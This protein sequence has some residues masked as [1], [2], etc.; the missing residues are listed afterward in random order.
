V[1]WLLTLNSAPDGLYEI[2]FLGTQFRVNGTLYD[3]FPD[4]GV[5]YIDGSVDVTGVVDGRI[6]IAA[7][8]GMR[9]IGDLTYACAG[10]GANLPA[11]CDDV[12]GLNSQ[13]PI[14]I[15]YAPEDRI[16]HAAMAS[17]QNSVFVPE[18]ATSDWRVEG[19]T[20]PPILYIRGAVVGHYRGVFGG[21]DNATSDL[22]SFTQGELVSGYA[23]NFQ[24]DPRLVNKVPPPYFVNPTAA[25]WSRVDI[26]QVPGRAAFFTTGMV[27]PSTIPPAPTLPPLSTLPPLVTTTL[28]PIAPT[29]LPPLVTT[30][31]APL[32]GVDPVCDSLPILCP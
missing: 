5:I 16:V 4:S 31:T 27:T 17:V 15:P 20:R 32:P 12:I 6:S 28:P 25:A 26:A 10:G 22:D 24:W 14:R 19:L 21:Y 30:T 11:D 9:I 1:A 3:H 13:Q 8:G 29:T 18:W 7:T 23:K 2:E